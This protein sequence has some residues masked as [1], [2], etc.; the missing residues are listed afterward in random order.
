M[1]ASEADGLKN[2]HGHGPL[3]DSAIRSLSPTTPQPPP[4]GICKA[5]DKTLK[6]AVDKHKVSIAMLAPGSGMTL[7]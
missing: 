5:G 4:L 7:G 2:P 3:L 6:A 1:D